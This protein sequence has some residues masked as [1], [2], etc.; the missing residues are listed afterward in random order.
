VLVAPVTPGLTQRFGAAR[1][2][3][4]GLVL[5]AAGL[6]AVALARHQPTFLHLLPGVAAIGIGS[7]LTV[8]LTTSVLAAVPA[9]RTGVAG[10]L[11]GVAREASGLVGIAVIGLIVSAGHRVP[12]RGPLPA[13]FARGYGLGLLAA[14]GLAVLGAVIAGRT[15]PGRHRD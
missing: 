7:A 13:A 6:A 15:L 12:S 4:A 9:D 11:L 1:T 5:V 2:V 14:A 3:A 8:P 10:G